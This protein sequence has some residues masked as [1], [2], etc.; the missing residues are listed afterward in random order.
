MFKHIL[1]YNFPFYIFI[2]VHIHANKL[3]NF[4]YFPHMYVGIY[5]LV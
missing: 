4:K 5:I 3:L 1:A 2:V